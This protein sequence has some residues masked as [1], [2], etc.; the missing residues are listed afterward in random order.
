MKLAMAAAA[1][2]LVV[3][4]VSGQIKVA[5]KQRELEGM[6]LKVEQQIEKNNELQRLM[7]ED[8]E[9]AYIERVAREKLGHARPHERV[10]VDLTGQ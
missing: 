4:L 3:S 5:Q 10:F 1:I 7:E 9:E 2:Y 6:T 8:D